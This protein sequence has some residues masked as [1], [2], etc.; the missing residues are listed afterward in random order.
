[1]SNLP[2]IDGGFRTAIVDPPWSYDSKS[3]RAA[4]D[5]SGKSDGYQTMTNDEIL[6]LPIKNIMALKSHMYLWCTDSFL[7][8]GL[9]CMRE[10]GFIYKHPI[11]WIK[12]RS[13]IEVDAPLEVAIWLKRNKC[14]AVGPLQIGMGSY[15]RKAHELCL[16]GTRGKLMPARH[17]RPSVIEAPK[18]RHSAKPDAF[19]GLVES[20]SPSPR[21][22]IFARQQRLGWCSYGNQLP[23]VNDISM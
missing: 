14:M 4:P 20:M 22:E 18:T 23:A 12:R 2:T 17:D 1:M 6:A 21:V 19:Y 5:W 16:F 15:Y 11:T 7:E 13:S 8:L 9:Q 3:S 10:W